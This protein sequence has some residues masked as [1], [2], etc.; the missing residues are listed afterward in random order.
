MVKILQKLLLVL[1]YSVHY[2]LVKFQMWT[3]DGEIN[4]Q[5]YTGSIVGRNLET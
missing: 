3:V 4:G 5:Q 1:L 2:E